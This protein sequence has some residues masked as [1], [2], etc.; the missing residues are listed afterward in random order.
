MQSIE[1][2][3][4][5]IQKEYHKKIP[6]KAITDIVKIA[7]KDNRIIHII[8]TARQYNKNGNKYLSDYVYNFIKDN[9]YTRSSNHWLY[10]LCFIYLHPLTKIQV[11]A[12][13]CD[14]VLKQ[15]NINFKWI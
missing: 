10:Y 8:E 14:K 11:L 9:N 12:S 5:D 1:N 13:Q 3:L 15:N 6:Q 7:K 4:K 2:Q